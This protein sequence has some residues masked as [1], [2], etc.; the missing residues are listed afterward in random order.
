MCSF[1]S[2]YRPFNKYWFRH[3]L[4][5]GTYTHPFVFAYQRVT[6]G[7]ADCDTWNLDNYLLD[8]LPPVLR[9][10][11]AHQHGVP[12]E[13]TVEGDGPG[14]ERAIAVW[15]EILDK[16]IQ[17]F[18]CAPG[19]KHDIPDEFITELDT[20]NSP[21]GKSGRKDIEVDWPAYNKWLAEQ[22]AKFDEGMKLFHQYFFALWD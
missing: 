15:H 13:L 3:W 5:L 12:G 7:W 4:C 2:G 11:K 10:L 19:V 20:Y 8:I 1:R 18:E 14:L 6:R 21:F 9:Y 16:M 22:Q 17:G